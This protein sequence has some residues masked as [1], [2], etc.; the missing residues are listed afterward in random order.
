MTA[1][2]TWTAC[3]SPSSWPRWGW[4]WGWAGGGVRRGG[5]GGGGA[6]AGAGGWGGGPPAPAGGGGGGTGGPGRAV[7]WGRR[8]R[9]GRPRLGL[10]HP[11]RPHE[12][13]EPV[14]ENRQPAR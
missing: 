7:R 4:R 1:A 12:R 6:G 2:T 5:W 3:C 9:R 11:V 10:R 8:E 13:L 14:D